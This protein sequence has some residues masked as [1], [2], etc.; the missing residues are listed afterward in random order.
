MLWGSLLTGIATAV[1]TVSV[2]K[3]SGSLTWGWIGVGSI[4]FYNFAFAATWCTGEY[5][6]I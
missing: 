3:S 6:W 2:A 1:F 5:I 4:F